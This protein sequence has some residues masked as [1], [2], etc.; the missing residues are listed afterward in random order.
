[1]AHFSYRSVILQ[2]INWSWLVIAFR[3]EKALT[4]NICHFSSLRFFFFFWI[5]LLLF[6][7]VYW[8]CCK[9]YWLYFVYFFS[10]I[11]FKHLVWNIIIRCLKKILFYPGSSFFIFTALTMIMTSLF[12]FK[13]LRM[14]L[15]NHNPVPWRLGRS[16][17]YTDW[18]IKP[19]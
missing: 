1:M 16:T 6:M 2:G 10:S 14:L 13:L 3:F 18:R 17:R 8:K 19:N 12:L 11:K 15:W 5:K 9:Y 4:L 7:V